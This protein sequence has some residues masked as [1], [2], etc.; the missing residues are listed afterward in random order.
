MNV[1]ELYNQ[2]ISMPYS[3]TFDDR[4]KK[5][6]VN[7]DDHKIAERKY[8]PSCSFYAVLVCMS[9]FFLEMV[10]RLRLAVVNVPSQWDQIYQH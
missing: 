8:L 3:T 1:I 7:N 6:Q 2:N 4:N 9:K 5:I 10:Y